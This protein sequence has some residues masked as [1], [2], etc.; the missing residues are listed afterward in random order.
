MSRIHV[1]GPGGRE[2]VHLNQADEV[3]PRNAVDEM[4]LQGQI[5]AA[6]DEIKRRR[7]PYI[8]IGKYLLWLV[9]CVAGSF[10]LGSEYF[11][12]SK[13]WPDW[14]IAVAVISLVFGFLMYSGRR[15]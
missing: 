7:R 12:P 5:R 10:L 8:E 1:D 4:I 14:M 6:H 3:P 9:A 2:E 11:T 13:P 15:R